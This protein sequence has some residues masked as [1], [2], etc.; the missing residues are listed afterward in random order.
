L[1]KHLE[2]T[3]REDI[4]AKDQSNKSALAP[5]LPDQQVHDQKPRPPAQPPIAKPVDSGVAVQKMLEQTLKLLSQTDIAAALRSVE[6]DQSA[7]ADARSALKAA[8]E[9]LQKRD[10]AWREAL[11]KNVGHKVKIETKGGVVEG[12]VLAVEGEALKIDKPLVINGEVMGSATVAVAFADILPASRDAMAPLPTPDTID[13]WMGLALA[14][15]AKQDFDAA[16]TALAHS[17]GHTLQRPF[18]NLE[19]SQR[20]TARESK[21]QVVWKDFESRIAGKLAQPQAKTLLTE[22]TKFEAEFADA[23]Y[24]KDAILQQ[25]LVAAKEELGRLSLGLDPRIQ[26]AFKGHITSYDPRT[27]ILSVTYDFLNKEQMEDFQTTKC[28][29]L[30]QS[31]WVK[32][33]IRISNYEVVSH[34]VISNRFTTKNLSII[35][36]YKALKGNN[37]VGISFYTPSSP[38]SAPRVHFGT[39]RENV[40]CLLSF[41]ETF[42]DLKSVKLDIPTPQSAQMEFNCTGKHYSVKS[43]GK[44]IFAYDQKEENDHQGFSVGGGNDSLYTL[45]SLQITGTLDA[46]W[47]A[48]LN[49]KK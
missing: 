49:S 4:A 32:G 38:G 45:T 19:A 5:D 11:A 13:E 46:R 6:Q 28:G 48:T 40:Y 36:S 16:D 26:A 29:T 2:S 37:H 24:L 8:L 7:S 31:E 41:G 3:V 43:N 34:A 33:G 30:E 25:K 9:T 14:C 1:T 27:Q 22:L 10:T 20:T 35:F 17:D 42:A 39:G 21:A 23:A 47:L 15:M 12:T 44:E 18:K